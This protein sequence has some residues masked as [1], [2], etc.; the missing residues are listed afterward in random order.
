MKNDDGHLLLVLHAPPKP[1]ESTRTG[2]FFW[3]SPDGKWIS[4]EFGTGINALNSHLDSYQD[5]ITKLDAQEESAHTCELIELL[6]HEQ[7]FREELGNYQPD[8]SDKVIAALE[9]V[10]ER[11]YEPCFWCEW[12]LGNTWGGAPA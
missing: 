8:I 5:I 6:I 11:G 2:R 10:S 1:D 7:Y 12:F 9:W 4:N 3:R